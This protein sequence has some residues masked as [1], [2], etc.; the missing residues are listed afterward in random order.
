MDANQS[1]QAT[2]RVALRDPVSGETLRDPDSGELLNALPVMVIDDTKA[3]QEHEWESGAHMGDPDLMRDSDGRWTYRID[4]VLA[5]FEPTSFDPLLWVCDQIWKR[6]QSEGA[7]VMYR[8]RL[9]NGAAGY[10]HSREDEGQVPLIVLLH[11]YYID[12]HSAS[13][14]RINGTKLTDDEMQKELEVLAH[15]YGHFQ[16]WNR[17]RAAGSGERLRWE[18]YNAVVRKLDAIVDS[19]GAPIPAEELRKKCQTILSD[20]DRELILDEETRAWRHGRE[21][22]ESLDYHELSHYDSHAETGIQIYRYRLGMVELEDVPEHAR[23]EPP[24]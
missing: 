5:K 14:N 23:G 22:L 10:F 20:K 21:A 12:A 1:W 7:V 3:Y 17:A 13:R 15:E 11:P 8:G 18:A 16:S 9:H 19:E 4:R 24:S 2:H 6:A